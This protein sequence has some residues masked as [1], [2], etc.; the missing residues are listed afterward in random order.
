MH[1]GDGRTQCLCG[2]TGCTHTPAIGPRISVRVATRPEH[3]LA[4]SEAEASR[5]KHLIEASSLTVTC[6]G[7]EVGV[8]L[9]CS[10]RR[11]GAPQ[12]LH[13]LCVEG[14]G[15]RIRHGT[16]RPG[17]G[18][19]GR[20]G[21]AGGGGC[22][23]AAAALGGRLGRLHRC[24]GGARCPGGVQVRPAAASSLRPTS[25][26]H[27]SCA[28]RLTRLHPPRS[29][30]SLRSCSAGLAGPLDSSASA[31]STPGPADDQCG[32][33]NATHC[34]CYHSKSGCAITRSLVVQ[35]ML[36]LKG[37]FPAKLVA[38]FSLDAPSAV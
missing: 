23:G 35:S 16:A 31:S 32:M 8:A 14:G 28:A 36:Q 3:N 11:H 24:R 20:S 1:A 9:W 26:R 21:P 15:G 2:R 6:E 10:A 34:C 19:P 17:A 7:G 30:A 5:N 38:A 29:R 25:H 13:V 4:A 18:L 22:G 37:T 12:A 27:P 33:Q